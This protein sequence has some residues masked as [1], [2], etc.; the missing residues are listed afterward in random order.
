MGVKL[1]IIT[2]KKSL[3]YI[4]ITYYYVS[5]KKL[6]EGILCSISL[7]YHA[8][9]DTKFLNQI[10]LESKIFFLF[11]ILNPFVGS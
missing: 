10:F 11:K 5:S 9:F 1:D 3:V 2:V 7:T 4:I 8:N 6:N